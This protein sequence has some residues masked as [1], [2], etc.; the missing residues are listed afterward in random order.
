[1]KNQDFNQIMDPSRR[2]ALTLVAAGAA[3][4]MLAPQLA[5][6][7]ALVT[8]G[9]DYELLESPLATESEPGK[10]EVREF[11]GY[12]CPHCNDFEP[13]LND[14]AKRQNTGAVLAHTP[15]AWQPAQV[16]YQRLFYTLE[17]LG[18]ES[19]LRAH[20][21]AAIHLEHNL[22]DTV[23]AQATWAAKNGLDSA[24]FR[25][26]YASF[27]VQTKTQ[28]ATQVAQQ[29]GVVSIPTLIVKGKYM[30]SKANPLP[31]V[32]YLVGVER[33]LALGKPA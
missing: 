21:F 26:T 25:E 23:D 30:V 10:I 32:D 15:V 22:L 3:T 2:K 11:F 19:Q 33:R 12:W 29:A 7:Q 13:S 31:V 27:T 1:M 16:P 17:A 20:V 5:R 14:W 8:E 9:T 4:A 18:K 24:K 28:R 6:T